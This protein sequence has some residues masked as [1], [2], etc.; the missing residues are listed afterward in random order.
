MI[1]LIASAAIVGIFLTFQQPRATL[2]QTSEGEDLCGKTVTQSITLT[3]DLKCSGDGLMV[4]GN[5]IILNLNGFALRGS[6][7]D[8]NTTGIFVDGGKEVR[9]KGPGMILFFGTGI[10]YNDAFGGTVRDV[11]VGDN[12]VGLIAVSSEE[13]QWKQ[14]Y[15]HDNTVGVIDDGSRNS[16]VEGVQFSSNDVA[17]HAMSN[18]KGMDIDFNIIMDGKT[19]VQVDAGVK[20]TEVFYNTMFRQEGLDMKLPPPLKGVLLGNND[21]TASDPTQYCQGRVLPSGQRIT[22]NECAQGR[23]LDESCATARGLL[24]NDTNADTASAGLGE[25]NK[26][27]G[28]GSQE[29]P[30]PE[31]QQASIAA[32]Q[33]IMNGTQQP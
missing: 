28:L 11:Q 14:L 1:A 8:S 23:A 31:A 26:E 18:S 27:R 22:T 10:K 20:S 9:I 30:T 12:G 3:A 13:T 7:A 2:A 15:L 19:G 33:R 4:Q 32:L 24:S 17:V 21:C 5:D 6:G 16:E 25:G 29:T